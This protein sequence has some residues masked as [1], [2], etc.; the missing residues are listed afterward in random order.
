M[1]HMGCRVGSWKLPDV[2]DIPWQGCEQGLLCLPL[3]P[4]T[5]KM[6]HV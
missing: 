5:L 1:Q 6:S 4:Q 3:F 2:L